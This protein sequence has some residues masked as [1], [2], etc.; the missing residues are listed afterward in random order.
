[1]K[2]IKFSFFNRFVFAAGAVQ[3]KW[4]KLLEYIFATAH[5]GDIRIWDVRVRIRRRLIRKSF[6][7]ITLFLQKGSVPVQFIAAHLAKILSFDWHPTNDVMFVSTSLDRTTKVD[8]ICLIFFIITGQ[9]F[10]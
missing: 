2:N 9:N 5:E 8:E 7:V 10:V 6:N 1:M 3:V 4:C